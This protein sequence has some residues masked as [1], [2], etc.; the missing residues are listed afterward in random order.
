MQGTFSC[1]RIVRNQLIVEGWD[2]LKSTRQRSGKRPAGV[3]T[4]SLG[5]EVAT[6]R[7]RILR[8]ERKLSLTR[9]NKK[10][11]PSHRKPSGRP[12]FPTEP[13]RA[14]TRSPQLQSQD[15]LIQLRCRCRR[16]QLRAERL[17]GS[18]AVDK[19]SLPAVGDS[20]KAL[21]AKFD[22]RTDRQYPETPGD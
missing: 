20:K 18:V 12:M 19:E 5:G 1:S 21:R 22:P 17:R 3:P 8:F 2:A 14:D 13:I 9:V 10:R 16:S 7:S 4:G 6:S 15:E 11:P